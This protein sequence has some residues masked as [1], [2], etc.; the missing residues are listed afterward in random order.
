MRLTA[1]SGTGHSSSDGISK[2]Q[3]R[4]LYRKAF[5]TATLPR[6][7]PI[8]PNLYQSS[9]DLNCSHHPLQSIAQIVTVC[10]LTWRALAS[11]NWT[12]SFLFL[13]RTAGLL[14][15]SLAWILIAQTVLQNT[16]FINSRASRITMKTLVQNYILP[17]ALLKYDPVRIDPITSFNATLPRI[18]SIEPNLY[19]FPDNLDR[20]Y[21]PLPNI[22]Q[23]MTVCLATWRAFV[24]TKWTKVPSLSSSLLLR[25]IVGFLFRSV[26]WA[27][28]AQMVLQDTLFVNTR[29]SRVTTKTLVQNNS[30]PSTLSKYNPVTI[31]PI[32]SQIDGTPINYSTENKSFTM[33]VHYLQYDNTDFEKEEVVAQEENDGSDADSEFSNDSNKETRR[34]DAMYLQHGFGASSLS[35]LPVLPKLAKQMNARVALGH[36]TVG[37]GYTD[38]PKD[39]RWYRPRQGARIAKAILDGET[40]SETTNEP[41]CLVGHSMGSRATLRLATQLPP[42]TPKLIVLSSPALG[43][44][45]ARPIRSNVPPSAPSKFASALAT[46]VSRRI[47]RP[48]LSYLLRRAIGT[49]G[50]WKKGLKQVWGDANLVNEESD[51]TR[52]SWPAVGYGWEEGILNF[53]SAQ[54]LPSDDELDDDYA[55]MR[56]VLHLPNTKVVIVLG[57]KD[58]VIPTKSV[59][60][61]MEHVLS[62]GEIHENDVPIVEL[63]LGHN[64]FEEEPDT[65][66]D[67]LEHLV[68]DHWDTRS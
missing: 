59:E 47:V 67:A 64:A 50:F 53:A 20:Y 15:R 42:E 40:G 21:K 61:F 62:T 56:E 10:P 23:I 27:L 4:K 11:T 1:T 9:D 7:T 36:D 13:R 39:Q 46:T 12:N 25:Q 65:F 44:I 22:V 29:P 60:K 35:W 66:I 16:L 55:L 18:S 43:L 3:L 32:A 54:L 37:F 58:K 14:V 5:A 34:F 28:I 2:K 17:S 8:N 6:A 19:Q 68:R 52:Y 49:R 48:V 63:D 41:V 38:R 57:S 24:S 26:A 45:P 30:L 51:V 33:G 31:D